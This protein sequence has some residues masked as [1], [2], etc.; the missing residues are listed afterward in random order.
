VEQA[1]EG[2]VK[3]MV[4][5]EEDHLSLS[6]ICIGTSAGEYRYYVERPTSENDLHGVGAFIWAVLAVYELS[7]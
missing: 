7:K 6:G 2:L 5:V 4:H 1:L 3:E